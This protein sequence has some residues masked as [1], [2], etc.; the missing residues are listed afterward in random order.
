MSEDRA[1]PRDGAI[2]DV[3]QAVGSPVRLSDDDGQAQLVLDLLPTVPTPVWGRDE[4]RT[5]EMW[6]SNS[7]VSWVLVAGG[8]S[9]ASVR[10]PTG[11]RAPGWHAGTVIAERARPRR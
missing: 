8:V 5:G 4:F 2:P 10:P 1:A 7:V 11:V 6:N 9:I 3:R